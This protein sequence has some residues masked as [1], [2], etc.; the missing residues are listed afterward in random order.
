M[1]DHS[2][3]EAIA[4]LDPPARPLKPLVPTYLDPREWRPAGARQPAG[5]E[6]LRQKVLAR[7][8][9]CMYCGEGQGVGMHARLEVNHLNGY[10]DNRLEALETVCVLCHRVLHGGRSAAIY[11]SLLLFRQ[12]ACDQNTLNQLCWQARRRGGMPDRPL[13]AWL[14]LREQVPFRMDRA[15]LAGLTGYVVERFWLL[16]C[17][18]AY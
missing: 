13:M 11:G 12:A 3:R 15:Y 4:A 10:R 7:D 9:G 8:G 1:Q 6:A 17:N 16:E 5:W 18:A 14:G 2:L